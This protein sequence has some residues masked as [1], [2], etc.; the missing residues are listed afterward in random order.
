M[1]VELFSPRGTDNLTLPFTVMAGIWV[2]VTFPDWVP[3]FAFLY[4]ALFVPFVAWLFGKLTLPASAA[5]IFLATAIYITSGSAVYFAL[6][7][8]FAASVLFGK[9]GK[10]RKQAA[11][12]LHARTGTRGLAQVFANG[13]PSLGFGIA[14]FTTGNSAFI[15]AAIACFAAATADTLSSEIGML[16]KIPPMNII[17]FKPMQKGLSGGVSLLGFAGAIIGAAAIATVSL[18][19]STNYFWFVFVA[20][21]FGSIIDS[22]LGALF[23]AKYKTDEGFTE[24]PHVG[25]ES[26]SARNK[27]AKPAKGF[28]LINNDVVNFISVAASGGLCLLLLCA[29]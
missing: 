11:E 21:I 13:T 23:Q 7:A 19:Y 22:V 26:I 17:T 15:I 8:F 2:A 20:G 14:H 9:L 12:A 24:K 27:Q 5:A 1:L 29:F 3:H 16:S 18:L 25:A 4:W 6:F 28:A 10:T